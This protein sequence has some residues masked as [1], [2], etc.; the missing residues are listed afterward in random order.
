ML[1]KNRRFVTYWKQQQA[2]QQRQNRALA[3]QAR[4]E[5][6]QIVRFLSEAYSVQQIILF[7]SLVTGHFGPTSD[8]DLAVAGLPA[9]NFFEAYG[10]ITRLTQFQIDLKPLESLH[11]H[12]RRRVLGQ[13]EVLYEKPDRSGT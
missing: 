5:L 9:A 6:D 12:F 2:N 3:G 10:A 11:P 4:L 1:E 8:I 13:G 7:G